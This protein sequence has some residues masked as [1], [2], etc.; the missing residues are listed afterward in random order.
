MPTVLKLEVD[1]FSS[2][3]RLSTVNMSASAL[4]KF[5]VEPDL[6]PDAVDQRWSDRGEH[7][8]YVESE[9]VIHKLLAFLPWQPGT[10]AHSAG[11]TVE[12]SHLEAALAVF[13]VIPE[14]GRV[15]RCAIGTHSFH[16]SAS[17]LIHKAVE[18]GMSMEPVESLDAL[19]DR[20]VALLKEKHA[21][22]GNAFTLCEDDFF[23]VEQVAATV[24][25]R[26]EED[27]HR[28][29]Q[30]LSLDLLALGE[31]VESTT[32]RRSNVWCEIVAVLGPRVR[33]QDRKLAGVLDTSAK[34]VLQEAGNTV[35][36]LRI[37]LEYLAMWESR[38]YVIAPRPVQDKDGET[39]ARKEQRQIVFDERD[40][41][42]SVWVEEVDAMALAF[43]PQLVEWWM[44]TRFPKELRATT[45]IWPG[46]TA[47]AGDKRNYTFGDAN[48]V[49]YVLAR[50]WETVV[51]YFP[52]LRQLLG[53]L[54]GSEA[55]SESLAIAEELSCV[56]SHQLY[57]LRAL[58]VEL[59]SRTVAWDYATYSL[60]ERK[61][62]LVKMVGAEKES[63]SL[64]KDHHKL[65]RQEEQQKG[66]M[67]LCSVR[68]P[69]RR[70]VLSP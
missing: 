31:V 32:I 38:N 61:A 62:A 16:P 12:V 66:W 11:F 23:R 47:T 44:S 39:D 52:N 45:T 27:P 57:T 18:M 67:I 60:D 7:W 34:G 25:R 8:V 19:D 4:A 22:L 43:A 35:T 42:R 37:V 70:S 59:T 54:K 46:R 28:W 26:S 36:G 13:G 48:G 21:T 69:S 2:Q 3:A 15:L 65:S 5:V 58:E 49:R 1:S 50:R 64:A 53:G 68:G 51:T 14:D 56:K 63:L 10:G 24:F 33:K 20:V 17:R 6:P 30:H 40:E 55:V 41:C 29:M 9:N